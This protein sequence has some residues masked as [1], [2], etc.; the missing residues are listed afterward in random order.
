VLER[1]AQRSGGRAF[2]EDLENLDDVF[3]RIVEELSN[4]YL[5]CYPR[6]DAVRDGRWRAIRVEVPGRDVRIRTRQGYR[7]GEK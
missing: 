6:P 2:F 3:G 1:L 4:Q 5:L 7:V